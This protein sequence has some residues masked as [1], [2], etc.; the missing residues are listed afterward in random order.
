MPDNSTPQTTQTT[1]TSSV[2]QTVTIAPSSNTSQQSA[3][4]LTPTST[5]PKKDFDIPDL[6]REKY[7]DLIDLILQ[8]ESMNDEERQYWFHILPIMT[9]EQ[10]NKFRGILVKEKEQLS[11]LDK[12]Y[13]EEL[14]RINESKITAEK[15]QQ[16]AIKRKEL[17]AEEKKN[18]EE[19]K[20]QEENILKKLNE[21]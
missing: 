18:E 11:K 10:I 19:E 15:N 2:T 4:V 16:S 13:E 3:A 12:E 8:T 7:A 5:P 14:K 9:V 17:R 1:A 6:V 21:V 20:K